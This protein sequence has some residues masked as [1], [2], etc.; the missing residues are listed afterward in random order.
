MRR[1]PKSDQPWRV[2][3]VI[4]L[5]LKRCAPDCAN[6]LVGL[7]G[8]QHEHIF[9]IL[10]GWSAI[11]RPGGSRMDRVLLLIQIT[12]THQVIHRIECLYNRQILSRKLFWLR[13][14]RWIIHD[15][16]PF[17]SAEPAWSAARIY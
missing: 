10:N 16:W 9:G 17:L 12:S 13:R 8:K 6:I 11:F 5:Q 3:R 14:K 7:A 1:A 4:L 15:L 2:G